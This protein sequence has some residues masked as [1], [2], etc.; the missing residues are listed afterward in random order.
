[1]SQTKQTD[2]RFTEFVLFQAQ[3]AGLF[4]GLV[5]NPTT[6]QF[7]V[8]LRAAKS[9]L[10]SLEMLA[11]KAQGNLNEQEAKLLAKA[12]QNVRTLYQQK[13]DDAESTNVN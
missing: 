10:D 9:V 12:L 13:C 7:S 1:M 4:L 2:P 8:N 11:D 5:P 3:N 6:N